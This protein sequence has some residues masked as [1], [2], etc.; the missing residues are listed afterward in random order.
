MLAEATLNDRRSR[1]VQRF[2]DAV[3]KLNA[4][5]RATTSAFDAIE[6]DWPKFFQNFWTCAR[7]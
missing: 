5:I 1:E 7:A 6:C 3:D 4:A 2:G